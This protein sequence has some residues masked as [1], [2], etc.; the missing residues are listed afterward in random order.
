MLNRSKE[1]PPPPGPPRQFLIG[2]LLQFPKDHFYERF[3]EW[4]REYGDIVSVEVPGTPVVIINSY[5]IVQEL[6]NKRPSTTAGRKVGYM[7]L[8]IMGNQWSPAFIQPGPDHSNQRKM[9]RRGLGP[10][11]VGSHDQTIEK[12][13]TQLMLSLRSSQGDPHHLIIEALGRVVIKVAYGN[14]LP[15]TTGEEL[16]SWNREV[17]ELINDAFFR[18]WPVDVFHFLRFIPSWMPGATFKR[19]GARS[20]W[21]CNQIR[22]V[23]FETVKAL[24]KSGEIGHSLATDLLNEFGAN[25][26]VMDTLGI[27]YLGEMLTGSALTAFVNALL[28]YPNV[29]KKIQEEVNGVTDGTRLPR[30]SDRPNLPYTEAV[31]KE[32]FRWNSFFPIGIPHVNSQDEVVDGYLIKAGTLINVNVGFILSDPKVWGDPE[33]FRPERFLTEEAKSLPNPL[34]VTF[35]FG[36]RVCPGMYLADRIG[37]HLGATVAALYDVAPL[38]GKSRPNPQSVEYTDTALR[39]PVGFECRFLPRDGR[40]LSLLKAAEMEE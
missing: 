17:A 8:R 35:G 29:S 2:N 30:I 24:H 13:V 3:C 12:N 7:V 39:L 5:D 4:Q 28:L 9:L 22:Q 1:L 19:I 25:D 31:W 21:L 33:N 18:F 36:M 37:F 40:T 26:N 11:R 10:Q 20:T 32:A 38:E 23:P 16:S 15:A 27:L 34:L 14:K 6:L